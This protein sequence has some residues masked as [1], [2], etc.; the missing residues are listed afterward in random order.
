M[1]SG[2][3]RYYMWHFSSAML[4]ELILLFALSVSVKS[5]STLSY[6][7]GFFRREGNVYENSV[8]GEVKVWSGVVL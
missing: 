7:A 3:I 6:G 5:K 4:T 8:G 1:R 2:K